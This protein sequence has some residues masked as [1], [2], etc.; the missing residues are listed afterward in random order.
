MFLEQRCRGRIGQTYDPPLIFRFFVLE[1]LYTH[2]A[3]N[4]QH[5]LSAMTQTSVLAIDIEWEVTLHCGNYWVGMTGGLISKRPPGFD[6]SGRLC[7]SWYDA[8]WL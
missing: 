1:A 7:V 3:L 6:S 5:S 8:R 2:R 4:N